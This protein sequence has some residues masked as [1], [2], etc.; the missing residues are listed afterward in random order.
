MNKLAALAIALAVVGCA[1]APA[2]SPNM[3]KAPAVA[4]PPTSPNTAVREP[5]RGDVYDTQQGFEDWLPPPDA[6]G[7]GPA[8]DSDLGKPRWRNN[9]GS[10]DDRTTTGRARTSAPAPRR[11]GGP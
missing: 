7:G 9:P 6:R 2:R 11:N 10:Y 4:L 3:A 8:V 5:K 1:R